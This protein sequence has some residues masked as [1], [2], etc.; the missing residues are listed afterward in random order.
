[1]YIIRKPKKMKIIPNVR[2]KAISDSSKLKKTIRKM[3]RKILATPRKK[4]EK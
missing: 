4:K 2:P 3:P 1:M